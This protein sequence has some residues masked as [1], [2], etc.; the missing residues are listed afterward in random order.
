MPGTPAA[1]A[2]GSRSRYSRPSRTSSARLATRSSLMRGPGSVRSTIP[3]P[4]RSDAASGAG[5][6]DAARTS[7]SRSVSATPNEEARRMAPRASLI[8]GWSSRR[9]APRTRWGTPAVAMASAMRVAWALVRTRTAW[10]GPRDAGPVGVPGGAGDGAGLGGLIGQRPDRGDRSGRTVGPQPDG[11]VVPWSSTVLATAEDLRRGSVVVL[12][13]DRVAAGEEAV[14][15]GEVAGV[16]AVPGIDGLVRVADD[17]Q[18]GVGPEPLREQVEL[19]RV[20][21]LELVDEQVAEPPASG[22][23]V[24]GVDRRGPAPRAGAGRRSRPCR[25]R[26]F[27]LLVPVVDLRHRSERR[28]GRGA[29]PCRPRPRTARG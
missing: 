24:D 28:G 7:C 11:H 16:G 1:L 12:E 6:G 8:S 4:V 13:L 17:A 10:C 2:P 5:S 21:V 27:S 15:V 9:P 25:L 22:G 3:V 20:D 18:V 26:R 14:E 29:G 19:Q 23:G